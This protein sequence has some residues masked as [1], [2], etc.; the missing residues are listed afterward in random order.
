MLMIIS[1]RYNQCFLS[2]S[3][4]NDPSFVRI[5]RSMEED[6]GSHF[7]ALE[8]LIRVEAIECED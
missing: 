4:K 7:V 2:V 1:T 8:L 5:A 3:V 6:H